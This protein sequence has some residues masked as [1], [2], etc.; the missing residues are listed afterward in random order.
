LNQLFLPFDQGREPSALERVPVKNLE[1][2]M[3][4]VVDRVMRALTLKHPISDQ[5]AEAIRREATEFAINLLAK[6]K[7]QLAQR[8]L[9][10]ASEG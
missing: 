6:Y 5:E 1:F 7:S 8:T 9:S 3:Q 2:S 10:G 4:A